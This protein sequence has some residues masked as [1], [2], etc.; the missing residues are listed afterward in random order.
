MKTPTQL[1]SLVTIGISILAAAPL[2]GAEAAYHFLKE[3]PVGGEGGWDYLMMDSKSGKVVATVPIG[4]RVDANTFDP[5]T[6]FAFA[7][8]GDGTVTVAHEDTP[9]KL[10]VVQT[11]TTEKGARTMALD[12]KTHRIYLATAKYEAAPEQKSGS[13]RQRPKMIPGSFKILVYG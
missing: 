7:S 1:F 12:P 3:I 2:R 10:T 5:G 9:D 8:C 6:Q 11:L 4:D 13:G